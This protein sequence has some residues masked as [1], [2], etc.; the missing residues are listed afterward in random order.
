MTQLM[1]ARS[2]KE[3]MLD[4]LR[5][6]PDDCGVEDIK[7]QLYLRSKVLEGLKDLEAGRVVSNEEAKR[8]MA[9]WLELPG[10]Q[11]P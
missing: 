7:Y 1:K 9:E 10:Q 11:Q 6:L 8:T 4:A 3:E 5:A 2:I